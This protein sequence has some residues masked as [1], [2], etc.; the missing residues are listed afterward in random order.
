MGLH[1]WSKSTGWESVHHFWMGE[2]AR[3]LRANLPP[4]YRAMIGATPLAIKPPRSGKPDVSVAQKV[5]RPVPP[6]YEE[7]PIPEPDFAVEVATLEE[8]DLSLMVIQG[9]RVISVIEL[10]SPRN[11]DRSSERR[12]CGHRYADYLRNGVNLLIVDVHRR[13]ALFS[14]PQYVAKSFGMPQPMLV[15]P[16]AVSFGLGGGA[17]S[18]GRMVDV[19]QRPL[20]VGE[21]LPA[22]TLMLTGI[23]YVTVNLDATYSRAASDSYLD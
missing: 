18:G 17:P 6:D 22:M 9:E 1:D 12:S 15:A 19:W 21:P 5:T 16:S 10:I 13:P 2:I 14:F 11:K 23:E 4:G 20:V 3:D 7:R 8:V